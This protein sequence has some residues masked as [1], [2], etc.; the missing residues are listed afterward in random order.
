MD[1]YVGK[2]E[3]SLT[4]AL[5]PRKLGP[6]AAGAGGLLGGPGGARSATT[7]APGSSAKMNDVRPPTPTADDVLCRVPA[8]GKCGVCERDGK[9]SGE[10]EDESGGDAGQGRG[11]KR[12]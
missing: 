8:V 2:L 9:G 6:A 3:R 7:A 10:C 12:G 1:R 5:D 4:A 11:K